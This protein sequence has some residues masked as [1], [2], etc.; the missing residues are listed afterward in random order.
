MLTNSAKT[1]CKVLACITTTPSNAKPGRT[2]R[3][4]KAAAWR[5]QIINAR[6]TPKRESAA[7]QNCAVPLPV[8]D[9]T[10]NIT[11]LAATAPAASQ[12]GKPS[13]AG[14]LVRTNSEIIAPE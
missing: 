2:V 12:V 11:L 8:W 9:I 14:F 1:G 5:H 3:S 7:S 13:N 6:A 4:C 10:I